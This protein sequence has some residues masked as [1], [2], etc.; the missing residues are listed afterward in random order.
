[1]DDVRAVMDAAGVE[2]AALSPHTRG[3]AWPFSSPPPI[4]SGRLRSSSTTRRR[5]ASGRRTIRGREAT[6]EWRDWLREVGDNG[7]RPS[8]SR[9]SSAIHADARR[10]RGV[11][12][13]VRPPHAPEREPGHSGRVPAHGHGRRRHRRAPHHP[14]AHARAAPRV[15]GGAGRLRRG[16]DPERLRREVLG[17]ST[18]SPGLTRR[19]TRGSW[20]RPRQFLRGLDRAAAPERVLATILLTDIVDSTR[21]AAELGDRRW[22]DLLE[23]HNALVRGR[24]SEFRGVELNTTGDGFV[25]SFD[26][27]VRAVRCAMAIR[28][29]VRG[30]GL[31]IRA[32]LH[33]GEGD[34]VGGRVGGSCSTSPRA[35]RRRPSPARCSPPARSETSSPGREWA[36]P[37]AAGTPSRACRA[38]GSSTRSPASRAG[39]NLPARPRSGQTCRPSARTST[40]HPLQEGGDF[41]ADVLRRPR[42]C[43][44]GRA[45]LRAP[46]SSTS[47]YVISG[48]KHGNERCC[49]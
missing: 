3:R 6:D 20:T 8:S 40:A 9:A 7:A 41:K 16:A 26:G 27:P 47:S 1:M 2:C 11:P 43:R 46:P 14:R 5:R 15:V 22:R 10:R 19:A 28:D 36:S 29:D 17:S 12:R 18:A 45:P 23:R 44:R 38:S 25:A 31:E 39:R 32:G 13:L 33:T 48:G 49:L 4:R 37:T 24:L 42:N 21:R 34:L 35:W 30:L